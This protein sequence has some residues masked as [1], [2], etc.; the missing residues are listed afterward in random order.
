V[1]ICASIRPDPP[2][3]SVRDTS[4]SVT[5][6]ALAQSKIEEDYDCVS[7]IIDTDYDSLS[8]N[9]SG[10]NYNTPEPNESAHDNDE[11]TAPPK[12]NL[13]EMVERQQKM[14]DFLFQ[15]NT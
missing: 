9:K 6:R 8:D 1:N 13:K 11:P 15:H 10:H 12:I 2:I 3:L 4:G 7:S 5:G 14:I